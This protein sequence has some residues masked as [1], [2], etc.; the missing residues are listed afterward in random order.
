M[1]QQRGHPGCQA[2]GPR[3]EPRLGVK[4]AS[5]TPIALPEPLQTD[6]V[7]RGPSLRAAEAAFGL[8]LLQCGAS[9]VTHTPSTHACAHMLMPGRASP[10]PGA[11]GVQRCIREP[12]TLRLLV[13][14]GGWPVV[15]AQQMFE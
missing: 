15:S 12:W 6:T 4:R 3:K 1:T 11:L 5:K 7:A 9:L 10:S 8:Q 14:P 13:F 2:V